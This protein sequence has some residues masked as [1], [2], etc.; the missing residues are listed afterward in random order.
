MYI[1]TWKYSRVSRSFVNLILLTRKEP[2]GTRVQGDQLW[3]D[4]GGSAK[5]RGS[6]RSKSWRNCSYDN[7]SSPYTL[8]QSQDRIEANKANVPPTEKIPLCG[9]NCPQYLNPDALLP[10]ATLLSPPALQNMK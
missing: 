5:L 8:T 1:Q 3:L 9:S 7:L 4:E 10:F 6:S 2:K